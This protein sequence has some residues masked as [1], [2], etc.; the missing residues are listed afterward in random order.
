MSFSRDQISCA[1]L[2]IQAGANVNTRNNVGD[3]PLYI[4]TVKGQHEI[5][6][7]LVKANGIELDG[8]VRVTW[9]GWAGKSYVGQMGGY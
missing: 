7:L 1:K 9:A 2:L 8:Q 4:A 5:L 3:F 6:K